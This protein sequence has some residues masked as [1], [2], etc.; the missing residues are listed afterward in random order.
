[1]THMYAGLRQAR[2]PGRLPPLPDLTA[3][4]QP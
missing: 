3:Q 1:M 4:C 2:Q